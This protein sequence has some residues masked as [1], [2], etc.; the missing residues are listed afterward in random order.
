L[1]ERRRHSEKKWPSL[2]TE[3][4]E[5]RDKLAKRI[6]ADPFG[7]EFAGDYS[8]GVRITLRLSLEKKRILPLHRFRGGRGRDEHLNALEKCGVPLGS[9]RV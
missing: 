9:K 1:F 8:G 6:L 4:R 3:M 5:R 2:R 7:Q